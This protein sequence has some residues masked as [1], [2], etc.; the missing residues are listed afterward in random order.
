MKPF[1]MYGVAS[2]IAMIVAF[3]SFIMGLARSQ[4]SDW[5]KGVKTITAQNFIR[6]AQNYSNE[7]P[8]SGTDYPGDMSPA[9]NCGREVVLV[10]GANGKL[11]SSN[12]FDHDYPGIT[13]PKVFRNCRL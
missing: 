11:T 13:G 2:S 8:V 6:M 7:F 4:E 9:G 1:V 5:L 3:G 10:Q 12:Y